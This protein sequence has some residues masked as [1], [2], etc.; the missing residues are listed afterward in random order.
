MRYNCPHCNQILILPESPEKQSVNCPLCKLDFVIPPHQPEKFCYFCE[1]AIDETAEYCPMCGEKQPG[2]KENKTQN[3]TQ[4]TDDGNLWGVLLGIFVVC[5]AIIAAIILIFNLDQRNTQ[6]V[7]EQTW[8]K[9]PEYKER[10]EKFSESGEKLLSFWSIGLSYNKF[11]DHLA[12][13]ITHWKKLN[14]ILPSDCE[15]KQSIKK[16][17][18]CWVIAHKLWLQRDKRYIFN[19]DVYDD[20]KTFLTEEIYP[21]DPNW[22][23]QSVESALQDV[24]N[25]GEKFYRKGCQ[26]LSN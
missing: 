26:K 25:T 23:S 24:M 10:F 3:N 18:T 14:E 19:T 5:G 2:Q 8:K 11:T 16:P 15:E 6:T 4:H 1:E 20:C 12:D 22:S 13:T 21:K 7:T 17:L 9:H